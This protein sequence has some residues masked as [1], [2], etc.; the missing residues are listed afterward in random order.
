LLPADEILDDGGRFAYVDVSGEERSL[1][2]PPRSLA[3][4]FCQVPVVYIVG[5]AEAA[6]LIHRGNEVETVAGDRLP[7]AAAAAVFSRTGEVTRLDVL[8]PGDE[9]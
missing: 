6:L 1:P 7:A 9:A 3:F 4:T 5:A 8:L 2:L